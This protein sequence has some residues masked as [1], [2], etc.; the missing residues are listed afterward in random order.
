MNALQQY[1]D[2]YKEHSDIINNNAATPLNE[3]RQEAFRNLENA[4]LPPRGA[5]N[6]EITDLNALLAPD[7]GLNIARVPIEVNPSASFRCDVPNL[8]TSLFLMLNDIWA[9]TST[10]RNGIPEGVIIDSLR[11]ASITHPDLVRKYYGK[12]AR[13]DN[14][15]VNLNT[16]LIQD[17]VFIYI[18]KGVHLDKPIQLVNILQ[19]G[20]PLMATRR[21]LIIL[22]EDAEAK[23]LVCDHTQ[24]PEVDFLS[25]QTIEIFAERNAHFDF[26]DLEESTERTTRLSSLYLSQHE[27]SNVMIDGITLFNGNTR[28]EYWC[29]MNGEHAELHLLGMG[30]EDRDRVTDTVTMIRHNTPGCHSNEL[31]KYTLDD[32]ARGSFTGR[33]YVQED[34]KGTEA[35]QSNRNL[36]GSDTA[37][38]MS[39]PQLEIYNDDVK[40]S[41][42]TAI[43]QLDAMQL[44]YMRTRGL[45]EA[46]A[47]LLLKQAFMADVIDGVRLPALRDRLR[48]LV[49]RRLSGAQ[50]LCHDCSA[51]NFACK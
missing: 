50:S 35:Y 12:I 1:I 19:N 31:F 28:N 49:E 27:G 2:L 21:M 43:G 36:L 47:R 10:A 41:H 8:S 11:H 15:L 29:E 4:F 33:I 6:H 7:F 25:L 32:N 51:D 39:K 13:K 3:L 16:L 40:C 38:M 20:A 26:Y 30:I 5:E 34:A 24:N 46:T 14:P 17:G 22:E 37:R 9:E 45:S 18:P 44:F 23:M 42:G 48:L